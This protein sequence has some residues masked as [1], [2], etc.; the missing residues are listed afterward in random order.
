MINKF[1]SNKLLQNISALTLIQFGNYLIPLLVLPYVSRIVGIQKYGELE[2]ARNLVFY[3]TIFIDYGFNL[4]A[5]RAVSIHR[6]EP[7]QLNKIVTEVYIAKILLFLVS[8]VLFGVLIYLDSNY[9]NSAFLL[10]T[11]YLI[12][13][14]FMI[15]PIW[16]F[17]G[18]EKISKISI[19]N[20][21]V[22]IGVI[23][24][25]FIFLTKS[26]D[27]WV[28]N[29]LQ[30][31][32]QIVIGLYTTY[33][34]FYK[35]GIQWIKVGFKHILTRLKEGLNV[36]LSTILVCV[37]ASF[38]FMILNHYGSKEDLGI[39]STAFKIAITVQTIMLIPFSQAFFPFMAKLAKENIH[40]FFKKINQVALIALIL[41]SIISLMCI[42]MSDFIIIVLFGKDFLG[43]SNAF[44][45]LS[46]LPVFSV[47]TNLFAYQGL[48]NLGKDKLFLG[49][50]IFSALVT[51][52]SSFYIIPKFGLEGCLVL[53]VVIEILLM[54]IST[55]AFFVVKNKTLNK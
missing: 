6:G 12:N 42:L 14:G 25:T 22:K 10:W 32:S 30:S 38:S 51:I 29:L 52:G 3:F 11:T 55:I 5:T 47:L 2:F 20:F 39:Y 24:M 1:K 43:A 53:R 45:I 9:S 36:F 4:T 7:D 37:I 17:Q 44:K 31:I 16:Y 41:M 23:F 49:I 18:V 26:T 19:L 33:Y 40:D 48:L 8:T 46:I 13:F 27:Y 34:L 35:D 54:S 21:I 15:F 50:H 28:Y